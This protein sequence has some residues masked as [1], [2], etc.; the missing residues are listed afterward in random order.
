[1]SSTQVGWSRTKVSG[2]KCQ[3]SYIYAHRFFFQLYLN[4]CFTI[5]VPGNGFP[6]EVETDWGSMS[7]VEM[8]WR[9]LQQCQ[10][11]VDLN[12]NTAAVLACTRMLQPLIRCTNYGVVGAEVASTGQRHLQGYCQFPKQK[13]GN[14]IMGFFPRGVHLEGA[15]G[16]AE[17]NLQYCSKEGHYGT[18]GTPKSR[19]GRK[20]TVSDLMQ[21]V[22]DGASDLELIERNAQTW[23]MYRSAFTEARGIFTQP[24]TWLPDVFVLWGQT[25][26]G[27]TRFAYEDGA[28]MIL[29]R[30]PFMQGYSGQNPTVCFDD[31]FWAGMD[32]RYFLKLIDRY[33]MKVED[34]GIRQIQWA[35]RRIYITSNE[36]PKDW[37]PEAKQV[38]KDAMFRR[39]TEVKEMNE[40]HVPGTTLLTHWEPV[41]PAA[42]RPRSRSPR[43]GSRSSSVSSVSSVASHSSDS[44]D[45]DS[46]PE[47]YSQESEYTMQRRAAGYDEVY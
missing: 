31:F 4:V 46:E 23:A 34:K 24:R 19:P 7:Q 32:I 6:G 36:D 37:W 11:V 27:K 10:H 38:H 30:K 35:P 26:T 47:F 9:Y 13:T 45:S 43:R 44:S 16:N 15:K 17:Q 22:R 29:Y 2:V 42:A 40:L 8:C 12:S 14:V 3:M 20:S 18:W 33:P 28:E 1:M 5:Q 21:M 25:G 39:F 41:A